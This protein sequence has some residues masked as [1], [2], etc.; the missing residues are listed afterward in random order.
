[1]AENGD[2]FIRTTKII[3]ST[4]RKLK[5]EDEMSLEKSIFI[6]NLITKNTEIL[7][8]VRRLLG[9][10]FIPTIDNYQNYRYK[11]NISEKFN[12]N[13]EKKLQKAF[14][15]KAILEKKV[16][17][18]ITEDECNTEVA[19]MC[20]SVKTR[21]SNYKMN[22]RKQPISPL[23]ETRTQYIKDKADSEENEEEFGTP[24]KKNKMELRSKR[25]LIDSKKW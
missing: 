7:N 8:G 21:N 25:L 12:S 1:M 19:K 22:I 2:D 16:K 17:K 3:I 18:E 24:R 14:S 6:D 13:L 9:V 11:K 4:Q 15:L 20:S 10:T 5:T 23:A